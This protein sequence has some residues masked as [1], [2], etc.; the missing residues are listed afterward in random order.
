VETNAGKST[1]DAKVTVAADTVIEVIISFRA[2]SLS[3]LGIK[4]CVLIEQEL[5][6]VC[7]LVYSTGCCMLREHV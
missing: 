5:A 2:K 3:V 1:I 6:C 7:Y 4:S